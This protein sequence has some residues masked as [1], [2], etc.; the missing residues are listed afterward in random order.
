MTLPNFFAGNRFANTLRFTD[1]KRRYQVES[2][3]LPGIFV[4]VTNARLTVPP[5]MMI[6]ADC[7]VFI[8]NFS[9][10]FFGMPKFFIFRAIKEH[11]PSLMPFDC[12]SAVI[13]GEDLKLIDYSGTTLYQS[14]F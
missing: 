9:F 11:K 13:G 2:F 6:F 4:K 3:L 10:L 7:A 8:K 1:R 12:P 5:P 14:P